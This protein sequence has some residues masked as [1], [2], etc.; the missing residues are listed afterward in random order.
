MSWGQPAATPQQ[1]A[2]PQPSQQDRDNLILAWRR[3]KEELDKAKE[4]EMELRTQLAAMLFPNPSA[5]T[6]RF[7]LGGGYSVKLVHKINYKLDEDRV[8]DALD[9][10][11]KQGNE[12]AFLAD[13]L[14]K[15]KH[16]LSIS[17]YKK[18]DPSNPSHK[19]I[20]AELDKV[21]TTSPGAPT[22][23]LEEPK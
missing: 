15:T 20:K 11:E 12:G 8:D 14:V 7:E 16:E 5:G 13:R 23:E 10:I 17:E 18:L 21:L 4:R 3:S 1:P 22:L 6:Q 19:K 9:N 2:Q